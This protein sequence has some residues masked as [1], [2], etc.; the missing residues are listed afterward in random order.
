M[1]TPKD[2]YFLKVAYALSGCQLVEQALKL[3]IDEALSHIRQAIGDKVPF[4]MSGEDYK[5][6]SLEK[7]IQIFAKLTDDD[8]LIGELNKFK[9]KRNRL[10]HTGI[11]KCLDPDE[12]LD[13]DNISDYQKELD[14]IEPEA[15]NLCL[16]IV[17][18]HASLGFEKL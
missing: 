17:M 6:S 14:T 5:D 2:E 11:T 8:R 15:R 1:T 16:K 13:Q 12:E 10:S 9:D 3:Y 7:L 18:K 4:K